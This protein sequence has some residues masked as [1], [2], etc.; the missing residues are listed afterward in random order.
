MSLRKLLFQMNITCYPDFS[1]ILRKDTELGVESVFEVMQPLTSYSATNVPPTINNVAGE[2]S[3]WQRFMGPK[4]GGWFVGN[5][6]TLPIGNSGFGFWNA[7]LEVY[8]LYVDAGDPVRRAGTILSEAEVISKGGKLRNPL[9][10]TPDLP[11]WY[12]GVVERSLSAIKI[13]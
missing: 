9:Y 2:R 10:K 11:P 12:S 8:Q 13:Y 1:R 5:A 4:G 3:R 7:K 6:T